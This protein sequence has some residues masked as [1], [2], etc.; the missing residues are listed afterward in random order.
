MLK[1]EVQ[2]C[3]PFPPLQTPLLKTFFSFFSEE[4]KEKKLEKKV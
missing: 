3:L 4:K 1:Y 2:H